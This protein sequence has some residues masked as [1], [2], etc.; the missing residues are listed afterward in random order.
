LTERCFDG[1]YYLLGYTVECAFKAYIARQTKEHDFP[2]NR[3]A[4]EAIYKHRPID[5][6]KASALERLHQ[7][8]RQANPA[9][10][11]N[12]KIVEA[13]SEESRYE[14]GRTEQEVNDFYSAVAGKEGVFTWLK[15]Y[16]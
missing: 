6:L 12:W 9:F 4:V 15:K 10:E 2:P 13:W 8:E 7:D 11:D 1:A 5:L 14:M 16:W 3:K